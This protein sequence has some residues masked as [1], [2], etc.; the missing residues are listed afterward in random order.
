MNEK[1]YMDDQLRAQLSEQL[2]AITVKNHGVTAPLSPEYVQEHMHVAVVNTE[3]NEDMLARCPHEAITNLSVIV[4]CDL[5]DDRSLL[6]TNDFVSLFRKSAEEIIE[7]AKINSARE[8]YTCRNI[9]QVLGDVFSTDVMPEI[10]PGS[11]N[12]PLYVLATQRGVDGAAAITSKAFL[13]EVHNRF[14]EDYYILPSSR[15]EVLAVPVSKAP[16]PE[17][18]ASVVNDVNTTE[19]DEKDFLSNDV[20]YFDGRSLKLADSLTEKQENVF[21]ATL[22]EPVIEHHRCH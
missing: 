1:T 21:D 3:K 19:V 9:E 4:R 11:D 18:L 17:E 6:V 5:G 2:A 14:G 7:Q 20:Y 12:C 15:H 13:E 8:G 16:E 10:I 22:Q